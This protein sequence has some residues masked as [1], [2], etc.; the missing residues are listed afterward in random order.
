LK[1]GEP[2]AA[3]VTPDDLTWPDLDWGFLSLKISWLLYCACA[4]TVQKCIKMCNSSV[5]LFWKIFWGH[6]PQSP[7]LGRG[8]GAPLQISP[9]RR[10]SASR[11]CASFQT[12]GPSIVRHW[13]FPGP[14]EQHDAPE[15]W[16][17][18]L[19]TFNWQPFMYLEVDLAVFSQT[20]VPQ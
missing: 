4:A 16:Q 18:V 2:F 7:I 20:K 19:S 9:P 15:Q 8:R 5:D 17:E 14:P 10:S 12:F 13:H 3:F 6:D 11:L 1:S